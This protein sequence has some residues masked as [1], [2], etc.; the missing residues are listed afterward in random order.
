MLVFGVIATRIMLDASRAQQKTHLIDIT[1]DILLNSP[2]IRSE[3]SL[4][5]YLD[6]IK[7]ELLIERNTLISMNNNQI[8]YISNKQL[9]N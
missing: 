6:N 8:F 4:K 1:H 5:L 2:D 3:H 7:N 9:I